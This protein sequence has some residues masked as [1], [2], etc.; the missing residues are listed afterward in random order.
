M[1]KFN[2]Q[3]V[4]ASNSRLLSIAEECIRAERRQRDLDRQAKAAGAE[5]GTWT[6]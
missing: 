3:G 6:V 2:S 5:C 4:Y 1:I